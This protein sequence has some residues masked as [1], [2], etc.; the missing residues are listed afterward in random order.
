MNPKLSEIANKT[1]NFGKGGS[2]WGNTG[3][4]KGGAGGGFKK[5]GAPTNGYSRG[6]FNKTG[7]NLLI[8]LQFFF[9]KF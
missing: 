6:G 3:Y 5:F 8:N 4:N 2:R 7:K 9:K 1:N